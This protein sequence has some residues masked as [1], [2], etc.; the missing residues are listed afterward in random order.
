MRQQL[1]VR[2]I[3]Q[4]DQKTFLEWVNTTA[5]NLYDPDI[6]KYSTLN[7][8]CSYNGEP[9]AYL[10]VQQALLLESLAVKPGAPPIETAQ[11]FR[12]LV[13]AAQVHASK[14]GIK[15]LYFVC[16]DENVVQV[17]KNHGFE[18]FPVEWQVVRMK[19]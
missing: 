10:P 19:L 12:D 14:L 3:N 7:V 9:V 18:V 2:Y 11:A 13:K 17:A 16:K 6:L 5:N 4:E 15:E 1:K 8:F